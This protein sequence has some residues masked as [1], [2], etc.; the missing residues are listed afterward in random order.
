MAKSYSGKRICPITFKTRKRN[1]G[2]CILRQGVPEGRSN[3]G[4]A[5]FKEV[6]TWPWHVEFSPG[7]SAVGLVTSNVFC[8][9]VWVIGIKNSINIPLL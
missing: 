2:F 9:V 8:K 6:R 5:H 1:I 7:V 4:C 3:E